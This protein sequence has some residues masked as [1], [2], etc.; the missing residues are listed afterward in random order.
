MTKR[1]Y[2]FG[3]NKMKKLI[4]VFIIALAITSIVRSE[5]IA[6]EKTTYEDE[7]STII[8]DFNTHA[9]RTTIS[10]K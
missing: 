1:P 8:N 7:L 6:S 4:F 2:Y 10:M 9:M 5:E 3:L